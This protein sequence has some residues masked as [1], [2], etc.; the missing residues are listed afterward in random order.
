[1]ASSIVWQTQR[2]TGYCGIQVAMPSQ[3][4]RAT[5]AYGQ[6][7]RR[8][9]RPRSGP[10]G[11]GH[12]WQ[13]VG[14]R[15]LRSYAISYR[16]WRAPADRPYVVWPLVGQIAAIVGLTVLAQAGMEMWGILRD[17]GLVDADDELVTKDILA[18]GR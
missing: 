17:L 1:M 12:V 15:Q 7:D 2:L 14:T 9:H 4:W 5:C 16:Y 10:G 11:A 3:P 8:A 18:T 13:L 6:P